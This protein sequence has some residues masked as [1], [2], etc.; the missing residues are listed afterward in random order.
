MGAIKDPNFES[1]EDD[2]LLILKQAMLAMMVIEGLQPSWQSSHFPE[3]TKRSNK[4][5][6]VRGRERYFG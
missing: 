6:G 2:E 1:A 4:V 5:V 3:N